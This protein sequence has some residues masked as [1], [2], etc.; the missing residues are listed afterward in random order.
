[1]S[2][3]KTVDLS[4]DDITKA[5]G[6]AGLEGFLMYVDPEANNLTFS[7]KG[8]GFTI[9]RCLYEVFKKDPS[10]YK[11]ISSAV[12]AYGMTDKKRFKILEELFENAKRVSD[13]L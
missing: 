1:M 6:D 11:L 9:A 4:L 5:I 7:I 13:I 8:K 10:F 12:L 3:S 2:K